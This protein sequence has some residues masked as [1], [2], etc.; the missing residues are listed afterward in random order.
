MRGATA[1]SAGASGYV[2]APAAG[3]QYKTFRGDGTWQLS[4]EGGLTAK[5]TWNASTNTPTLADGTGAAGDAYWVGTAGTQN[6]GS[7]SVAYAVNDYVVY[8]GTIWQKRTGVEKWAAPSISAISA[9]GNTNFTLAAGVRNS[10][11]DLTVS[12]GSGTYTATLSLLA[13]NAIAGSCVVIR[14]AMPASLNPTLEVRNL[15]SA[16]TLLATLLG[17]PTTARNWI[18]R[19]RFDGT[20]WAAA[21]IEPANERSMAQRD[22]DE[23]LAPR[24]AARAF[25]DWLA[26]DGAT[27]GA[28]AY[29]PLGAAGAIGTGDF[30]VAVPVVVP[31]SNPAT[32]YGIFVFSTSSSGASSSANFAGYIT[33]GG[34]LRINCGDAAGT[35][36][37][38][39]DFGDLVSTYGGRAVLLIVSRA[40]GTVTVNIGK[41]AL[42]K[43]A[44]TTAGSA[45]AWSDAIDSDYLDL[46]VYA[47]TERFAGPLGTPLLYNVAL[48]AAEIATLVDYGP[49]ALPQYRQGSMVPVAVNTFD[50]E[51][52]GWSVSGGATITDN[53]GFATPTGLTSDPLSDRAQNAGLY[54]MLKN[55]SRVRIDFEYRKDGGSG[56]IRVGSIYALTTGSYYSEAAIVDN[57]WQTRSVVITH[58]NYTGSFGGIAFFGSAGS[59]DIRNVRI[60]LLGLV[61]R[62]E[63]GRTAQLRGRVN[64]IHGVIASG[65]TP[66][67]ARRV[68]EP[69]IGTLSATGYAL[70]IGSSDSLWFDPGLIKAIRVKQNAASTQT[71]TVRLNSSGGTT[72]ASATLANNTDWQTLTLSPAGGFPFAAGDR[73]HFTLT[74]ALSFEIVYDYL[75]L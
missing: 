10:S 52:A 11:P 43:S 45:P 9:A 18:V 64:G 49:D 31:A 2:T 42:T 51:H 27:S 58:Y 5:G 3:D 70:G 21:G 41:A 12:A 1:D 16:G 8:N 28:R 39:A 65:V 13:T 35:N 24:L 40:G 22:V 19:A 67:P 23:S 6:L 25:G 69:I 17:H 37:R 62:S 29:F 34:V 32:T 56:S 71:V 75:S 7:G 60:S 26:F 74:G 72:V 30:T 68:A 63:V 55:G 14:V 38:F 50:N 73:L 53:A 57:T 33:S 44:D 15:T 61:V 59:Y 66:L 20:N 36:R 46:G 48:T 47:A 4:T 54:P